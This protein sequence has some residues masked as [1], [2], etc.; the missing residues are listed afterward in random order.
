VRINQRTQLAPWKMLVIALQ[1]FA[2]ILLE[3]RPGTTVV[4]RTGK[5]DMTETTTWGT[6]QSIRRV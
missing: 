5:G 6:R 1:W 4:S 3:S 2:C